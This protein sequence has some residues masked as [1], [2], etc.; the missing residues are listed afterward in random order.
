MQVVLWIANSTRQAVTAGAWGDS[1]ASETADAVDGGGVF[2]SMALLAS[3]SNSLGSSG[4]LPP[5]LSSG[6]GQ[7][8]GSGGQGGGEG[9][10][11]IV[12]PMLAAVLPLAPPAA[13]QSALTKARLIVCLSVCLSVLLPALLLTSQ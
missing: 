10:L 4:L 9:L 2:G 7:E 12:L 6:G 1:I 3:R 8:G 5:G 13:Q 11:W